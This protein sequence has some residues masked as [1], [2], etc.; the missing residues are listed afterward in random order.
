MS[1]ELI[2]GTELYDDKYR[3]IQERLRQRSEEAARM[4]EAAADDDHDVTVL[5]VD[6]QD[7][8]RNGFRLILSSYDH[9][10][11]VGEAD[12]GLSAYDQAFGLHPDV[13]LMDIRMPLENGI[14]A[15][16]RIVGE[17]ALANT[18]VLVLTTFDVD[19]YVYD[20]LSA[21]ASG[22]M[23]KD[24]EPDDIV[25]AI[26]VVAQG[27]A[28][29]QPSI[30]R[31]LVE[32]F[33]QSRARETGAAHAFDALTERER[34]ILT[35][36]AHGLNNDEIADE[37]VISPA[38]VKTHIARIMAK[39]EAHDRAQLVVLAYEHGLVVPGGAK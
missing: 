28:L 2:G 39:L 1:E 27:D 4:A 7:L 38:T 29:I 37:L 15:T 33:V 19:E 11:V 23:L 32:T 13:V 30:T 24:A 35:Y 21:G 18:H 17:E 8:V 6:D 25:R 12:N 10:K 36:V 9:I 14:E 34:E 5:I 3:Q 26:R 16:K 22:F 31:R 20:A